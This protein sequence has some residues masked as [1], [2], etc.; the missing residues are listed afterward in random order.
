MLNILD[1]TLFDGKTKLIHVNISNYEFSI[2]IKRY[3]TWL[4]P[5]RDEKFVRMILKYVP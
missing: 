4:G 2:D 3:L 5:A 1:I